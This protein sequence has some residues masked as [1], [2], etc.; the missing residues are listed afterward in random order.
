MKKWTMLIVLL[1]SVAA[2]MGACSSKNAEDVEGGKNSDVKQ[3]LTL[4]IKTEPPSLDPG[5]ATD[6]TSAWVLD[7]VFEGLYTTDEDG[8][9]VKGVAENVEISEDGTVYT[10]TIRDDSNWTDGTPV[11]AADFEYAW[12]RVLNPETGSR[13][14][15]YLYYIKGAEEYNMGEGTVED[16]G[17]EAIDEKKLKVT[18]NA[19][20]GYF[21]KLLTMWTYYPVKQEQV[22]GNKNWSTDPATYVSNGPFKMTKWAHDSEIVMEKNNDYY[23]ASVVKLNKVTFKMVNEA[24]TFYQMYKT[25]ELDLISSLPMDVLEAEQNNEEYLAV[26]RYGTYMY[27]FNVK[28]EPFTNEKVRKAFSLS[29]NRELVVN[30]IN[31]AGEIPAYG[32]VPPGVST[33]DGD[34]REVGGEYF[35]E[36][37]E[38]AKRLLEEGMKEEG[39]DKLPEIELLY[40]TSEGNKRIAEVVQEMIHKNLGVQVKLVNQESKTQLAN[41]N[42]GNFQMARMGWVGTFVDPVINL[43]YFLGGSPNNRTGWVNEEYDSLLSQSKVEQ[44]DAKR[45]DLLH[46]AEKVLM[47][48]MP[49]IPMYYYSSTYLTSPKLENVA[50]Y[51]NRQPFLKWAEKVD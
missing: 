2:V 29:V 20:L 46:K 26:P 40:T 19:P 23:D 44:D 33:P 14:A 6:T 42:Q 12:K 41:V 37:A 27:I 10:F 49:F 38:E 16:V 9:P 50:Y 11:T 15:F 5:L 1:L 32:M 51:V 47:D 45:Y 4:N 30:T 48:D 8:N 3:E 7:H 25:G 35:K 28:K 31:K 34:F 21:D 13:F 36:D 17:V 18:L 24:T 43:D 22:E 39:W